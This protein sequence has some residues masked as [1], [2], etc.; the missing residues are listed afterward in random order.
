MT[1]VELYERWQK[2]MQDFETSDLTGTQW[3]AAQGIPQCQITVDCS[4]RAVLSYE[5]KR[6]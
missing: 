4:E 2:C 1:R 3:Y 5:K 6:K